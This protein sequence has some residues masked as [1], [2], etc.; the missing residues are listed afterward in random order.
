[1]RWAIDEGETGVHRVPKFAEY[2]IKVN[3]GGTGYITMNY[4]PWCGVKLP[5]SKRDEWFSKLEAM[6]IDPTGKK[7]PK[8]FQSDAWYAN[9][10]D[11]GV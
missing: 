10:K 7:V 11:Q 1:M 5:E 8:E 6:N 2:G 4:C 9:K 3:D